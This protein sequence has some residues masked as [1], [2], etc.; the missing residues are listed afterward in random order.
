M[1][2]SEREYDEKRKQLFERYMREAIRSNQLYRY[3]LSGL[4]AVVWSL[5]SATLPPKGP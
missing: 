3:T 2:V 1:T 4:I 5:V